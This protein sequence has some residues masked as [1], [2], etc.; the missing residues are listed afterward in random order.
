MLLTH[1]GR[2]LTRIVP[3]LALT[4]LLLLLW[5]SFQPLTR[6]SSEATKDTSD[7]HNELLWQCLLGLHIVALHIATALIPLRA[8]RTLGHIGSKMRETAAQLGSTQAS[9]PSAALRFAII[10]PSYMESVETL[11]TTLDVLASHA[12]ARAC[13][14][15]RRF[16]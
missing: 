15:V 6:S 5:K 3:A 12:K 9:P 4:G 1:L 11:R 14:D 16:Q 8:F 10:M 13:Y 2:Y 7:R